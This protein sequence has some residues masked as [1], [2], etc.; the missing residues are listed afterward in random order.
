MK[1]WKCI[2]LAAMLTGTAFFGACGSSG[3]SDGEQ[4]LDIYCLYKGY[5]DE[6]LTSTIELFKQQAWVKEK[7]PDLKITYAQ[8]GVQAMAAQKLSQGASMNKF[9]LMFSV[10]LT[11][12]AGNNSLVADLTDSV[13]LAE[14]PGEPGVKVIDKIPDY[15]LE[16]MAYE[17]GKEREDGYDT[18]YNTCYIEGAY[19]LMY[20]ADI[21]AQL[22]KDVPVTTDE[23]IGLCQDVMNDGYTYTVNGTTEKSY[24]SIMN[25]SENDYW[26][27]AFE[28]WWAQYEGYDEF[29]NFYKG[30]KDSERTNEVLKQTGRLRS[31]QTIER[32][33]GEE[34]T[35]KD[36]TKMM[37]YGYES[38][39]AIN[40]IVCQ[41]NFLMGNGVF[42]YNGDYF[43]T[44]MSKTMETLKQ[45]GVDYDIRFMKMPVISSIVERL[46]DYKDAHGGALMPD[47]TL[48]Q[49]IREIDNDVLY[50]DSEAKQNGV[51]AADFAII[52][53]ARQIPLRNSGGTQTTAVPAYSPAKKVAFDFL[54]FMYTDVAIENFYKSTQGIMFPVK[55][56][57]RQDPEIYS[58]LNKIHTSKLD[59]ISG[60][61][62]YPSYQLP[63]AETFPLG[64]A[65][66]A[67]L[68]K[69]AGKFEVAFTVAKADRTTAEMIYQDDID[70]W[71]PNTW[72]QLVSR[73]GY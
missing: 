61:E 46:N 15:I 4:C 11:E 57:V 7:Y 42:H 3:G 58:G 10:L 49:I 6:W 9:D 1:R 47:T 54:R 67:P 29:V 35:K 14:V 2:T 24:V 23:F 20:N 25:A 30:I 22:H 52:A 50:E 72:L 16:R 12:Q 69:F 62:N 51:S 27:T 60:T 63:T 31:L 39:H 65:G 44:E 18:Y 71:D 70:Y 59:L 36:G 17:G 40:Y 19:G 55:Y 38:S 5:Q 43:A 21:L 48:Q 13:Y 53:E 41:T 37:G 56:D 26:K 45:Q 66:L 32:V 28:L 8:D 68:T 33:F 64:K 34:W 73:A